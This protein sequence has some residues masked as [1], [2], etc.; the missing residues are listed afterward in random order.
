MSTAKEQ[1]AHD[2]VHS[3]SGLL[4]QIE[5][6]NGLMG[7]Y[8]SQGWSDAEAMT[9][10]DVAASS[11]TKA[12]LVGAITSIEALNNLLGQGHATN[13]YKLMRRG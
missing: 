11:T 12:E 7:Q 13:L 3:V 1:W 2:M 4:H 8:I 6:L 5:H 9:D 10:A